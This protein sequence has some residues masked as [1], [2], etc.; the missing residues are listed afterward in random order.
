MAPVP[1]A[2]RQTL[3]P[4]EEGRRSAAHNR[5]AQPH[6]LLRGQRPASL[7][8]TMRVS[9]GGCSCVSSSPL[10]LPIGFARSVRTV[11]RVVRLRKR[12]SVEENCSESC[13]SVR[14]RSGPA[15]RGIYFPSRGQVFLTNEAGA[16]MTRGVDTVRRRFVLPAVG[17]TPA[18]RTDVPRLQPEPR[19]RRTGTAA[20]RAR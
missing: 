20:R 4:E 1:G 16:H 12:S 15:R 11:Q 19:C 17:R 7:Q 5:S 13:T 9:Q 18:I 8:R 14:E 6:P 10:G 2:R 3:Q